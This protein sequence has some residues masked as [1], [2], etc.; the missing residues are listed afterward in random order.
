M[1]GLDLLLESPYPRLFVI[2]VFFSF[3]VVQV[4]W[5]ISS[6]IMPGSTGNIKKASLLCEAAVTTGVLRKFMC[7]PD[8]KLDVIN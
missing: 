5:N 4:E 3:F 1:P 8:K 7:F 6:L 2:V